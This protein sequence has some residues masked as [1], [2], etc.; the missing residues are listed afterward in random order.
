[1]PKRRTNNDQVYVNPR[2][3][4][5]LFDDT[6]KEVGETI[7]K[8]REYKVL[9]EAWAAGMFA[10][11]V[12]YYDGTVWYLRP[13]PEDT[14]PDFFAFHITEYDD[15]GLGTS[16][17]ANFEIFEWGGYS[18]DSLYDAINRKLKKV[19]FQ[20]PLTTFICH[21]TR[22]NE[23]LNFIELAAKL[24]KIGPK[25]LELCL[26]VQLN[27]S[28]QYFVVRL[29]PPLSLLPAPTSL[30]KRFYEHEFVEKGLGHRPKNEQ[31]VKIDD[32]MQITILTPEKP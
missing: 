2:V 22:K 24:Q 11:T 30:P 4:I 19:N 15:R 13:N 26:L 7:F 32:Q 28:S 10:A 29:F 21:I 27:P 3:Y 18:A 12:S 6:R 1:M 9:R 23:P 20:A 5:E 14:A 16:E 8:A 25:I 31:K 17:T